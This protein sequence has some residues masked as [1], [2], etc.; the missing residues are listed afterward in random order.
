VDAAQDL[1]VLDSIV[2]QLFSTR[3]FDHG[4]QLA[5][6]PHHQEGNQALQ[7]EDER[8]W[9]GFQQFVVQ[10]LPEV[11]NPTILGLPSS[12]SRVIA[13]KEAEALVVALRK[14]RSVAE[15]ETVSTAAASQE[16]ST[17]KWMKELA[18]LCESL[19]KELPVV[20]VQR[21]GRRWSDFYLAH[22]QGCQRFD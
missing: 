13:I 11:E 18:S 4:F 9:N 12:A 7:L 19:L 20:S 15:A 14:M 8:S 3:S 1:L 10:K 21:L 2:K 22:G 6:S 5:S 17:P 16:G